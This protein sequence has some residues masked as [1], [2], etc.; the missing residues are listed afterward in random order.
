MLFQTVWNY[1]NIK[2]SKMEYK[3]T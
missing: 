3:A 2:A 1:K